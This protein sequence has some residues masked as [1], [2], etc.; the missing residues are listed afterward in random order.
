MKSFI[1]NDSREGEAEDKGDLTYTYTELMT[2]RIH[3]MVQNRF[4]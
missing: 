2:N 1:K 3:R 4:F